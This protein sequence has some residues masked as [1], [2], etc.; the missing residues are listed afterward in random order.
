M[1]NSYHDKVVE[2]ALLNISTTYKM[3]LSSSAGAFKG[4]YTCGESTTENLATAGSKPN[5]T[6]VV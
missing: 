4:V 3:S 6:S 1:T 5:G 2:M